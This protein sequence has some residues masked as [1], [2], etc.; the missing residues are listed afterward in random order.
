M[1][2]AI[3]KKKINVKRSKDD[4]THGLVTLISRVNMSFYY[5]LKNEKKNIDYFTML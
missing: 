5:I 2:L 1:K 3:T 4:W